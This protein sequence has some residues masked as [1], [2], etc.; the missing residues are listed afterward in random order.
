[1]VY[2][3]AVL[4]LALT[5]AAHGQTQVDLKT[6]SKDIDFS[7]ATTTK[8]FKSGT[9]FP[10][11]CGVGEAFFKT[12]ASPGANLY[13]CTSLNTW[14]LETGVIARVQNAGTNLPVEPTLNFVSG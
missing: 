6:Q 14:T 13:S 11:V 2:R 1:M 10:S 3:Y 7:A 5:F 12:D 9:V 8:P 4:L